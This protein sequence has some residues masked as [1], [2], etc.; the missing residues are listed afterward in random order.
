MAN[1]SKVDAEAKLKAEA[2]AK[3]KAEAE[4]KTKVDAQAKAKVDPKAVLKA[5]RDK[6]V[7][8]DQQ[9][10]V[11]YV[12]ANGDEFPGRILPVPINKGTVIDVPLVTNFQ[13]ECNKIALLPREKQVAAFAELNGRMSK[14]AKA[15]SLN[16]RLIDLQQWNDIL[17]WSTHDAD[18]KNVPCCDLM[19][20]F[21]LKEEIPD[22]KH[23]SRVMPKEFVGIAPKGQKGRIHFKLAKAEA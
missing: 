15:I 5:L 8:P 17:C 21:G 23:V 3:A 12:S 1:E 19:V 7:D 22:W 14:T 11:I 13:D 6:L 16:G 4:A 20:N 18:G 10:K 2:D 9:T